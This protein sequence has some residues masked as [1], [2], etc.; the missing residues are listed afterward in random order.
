MILLP[1]AMI[2]ALGAWSPVQAQSTEPA[3]G[4]QAMEQKMMG[5]C[6]STQKMKGEMETDL[7]TQVT[8][9]TAKIA[10]MNHAD[11]DKK[12]DLMA[13]IVTQIVAQQSAMDARRAEMEKA[14]MLHMMLHM[15]MGK[16]SM[17]NCPMMKDMKG[18]DDK[19]GDA[20]KE[21]N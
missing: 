19:P 8:E 17:E 5:C 4:E 12:L 14:M 7:K 21:Q 2:L 13:D 11:E 3:K 10:N 20:Q 6:K 1:L 18:M 9:L 15:Q 16:E